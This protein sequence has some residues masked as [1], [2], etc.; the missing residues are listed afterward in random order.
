MEKNENILEAKKIA[1][2]PLILYKI[3]HKANILFKIFPFVSNRP[4]I[5]PY[6][7]GRDSSLNYALKNSLNIM[8]SK[9]FSSELIDKIHE[10]MVY[11]L[12]QALS[13]D[14][15]AKYVIN[16]PYFNKL[17][18]HKDFQSFSFIENYNKKYIIEC[19]K[20]Q[21]IPFNMNIDLKI[22]EK[23]SPSGLILNSFI[24]DFFYDEI[25]LFYIPLKNEIT[26]SHNKDIIFL[27]DL[28]SNNN[29][30]KAINLICFIPINFSYFYQYMIKTNYKYIKKLYFIYYDDNFN[31][32]FNKVEIYLNL[33]E[34]KEN[35]KSIYFHNTFSKG[36]E[37]EIIYFDGY[38][39][40]QKIGLEYLVDNYFE[41]LRNNDKI[42]TK[43]NSLENIEFDDE[44]LINDIQV[45]RLRYNLNNIFGPDKFQFK[46]IIITPEDYN[47]IVNLKEKEEV[48]LNKKLDKF[49]NENIKYKILYLNMKNNSPYNK[50]FIYFCEKFLYYNKNINIIIIDNLGDANKDYDYYNSTKFIKKLRFPNLKCIIFEDEI[51]LNN[52]DKILK[53]ENN[54]VDQMLFNFNYDND[55]NEE[56]INFDPFEVKSFINKFFDFSNFNIYEG[57][58]IFKYY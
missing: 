4:F 53:E 29:Y 15:F 54:K 32:I 7:I 24:E 27:N 40:Y 49:W 16:N 17:Y 9:N 3:K 12:M 20:N 41:R 51:T 57:Y 25:I 1:N 18:Y 33:I 31:N 43:F 42:N 35:I 34:H 23:H 21:P 44:D 13:K 26:S 19:I 39:I 14:S 45:F 30:L 50:N 55:Y 46:L 11:K 28:N 2:K 36:R 56:D 52:K 5:L 22:I 6:L 37:K 38:I 47:N 10:F 58:I 48:N 8:K